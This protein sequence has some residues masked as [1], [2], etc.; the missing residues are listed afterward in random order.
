MASVDPEKPDLFCQGWVMGHH[1]S[2]IS[3]GTEILGGKEGETSEIP[4]LPGCP[5]L[6]FGIRFIFGAQCLGRIFNDKEV[7]RLWQSGG[8]DPYRRTGHRDGQG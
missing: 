7:V 3:E 2:C 4:H 5:A 1:H 8:W 6:R